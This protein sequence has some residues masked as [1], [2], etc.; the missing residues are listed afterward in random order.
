MPIK[1]C[2]LSKEKKDIV[3]A[4]R[5]PKELVDWMKEFGMRKSTT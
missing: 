1:T 4:A 3:I 5:I 2:E